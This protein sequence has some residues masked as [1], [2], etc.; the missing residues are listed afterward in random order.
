[1]REPLD[2]ES[3]AELRAACEEEIAA[4]LAV[5]EIPPEDFDWKCEESQRATRAF[6]ARHK[7]THPVKMLRLLERLHD[8]EED[9][10]CRGGPDIVTDRWWVGHC[11]EI[12]DHIEYITEDQFGPMTA[13][14]VEQ[15]LIGAEYMR[16][17]VVYA[18]QHRRLGEFLLEL[19]AELGP[20]DPALL[21]EAQA[22]LGQRKAI[23]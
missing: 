13:A 3:I 23:K 20:V 8:A 19:E 9:V 7:A 14:Q 18:E 10:P 12:A 15:V 5:R 11:K 22:F 4:A 21:D 6:A 16:P 2:D 1:M 17:R